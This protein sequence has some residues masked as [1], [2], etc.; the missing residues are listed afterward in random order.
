MDTRHAPV[1]GVE[2]EAALAH[3]TVV[4]G[5]VVGQYHGDVRALHDV[6]GERYSRTSPEFFL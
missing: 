5:V 3:K 1:P 6:C 4:E 2:H